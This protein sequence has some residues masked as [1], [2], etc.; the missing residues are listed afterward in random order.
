[1]SFRS[2]LA[3]NITSL[4]PEYVRAPVG[5]REYNTVDMS[6]RELF[7]NYLPTYRA[8][9]KAGAATVMTSFNE[10]AGVPSTANKWLLTDILRDLWG[11]AGMVVTD[12]TAINELVKH[13]VASEDKDAGL[14]AIRAGVDIDMQGAV[15]SRLVNNGRVCSRAKHHCDQHGSKNSQGVRGKEVADHRFLLEVN[16]GPH[17]WMSVFHPELARSSAMSSLVAER[18]PTAWVPFRP[19]A[20]RGFKTTTG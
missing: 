4:Q 7:E 11:F 9:V 16:T 14:L 19:G 17:W 2:A 6:Q 20:G 18:G 13:G 1:M 3:R 10:I 12:Y 15:Y 8:A 5:G